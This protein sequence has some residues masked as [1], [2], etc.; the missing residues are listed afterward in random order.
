[1]TTIESPAKLTLTLRITG[2][3]DDGYHLID[4]EMTALTI[5]DLV[6]IEESDRIEV[7]VAGPHSAGVATD[8]SNLVH[9]A[10]SALGRTARVHI[11]KNIP[12]GGGL[13]GGSS[14]AAAVYRWAAMTGDDMSG[15]AARIGADVPFS[16]LGGRA[17]VT[18]IGE[19]LEPLDFVATDITLFIPPVHTP[20][21]L[22]YRTWDEMGAPTGANGNDL[23]PAAV[24]AVPELALWRDRIT[25]AI[26]HPPRLAGSG[27]TWFVPGHI[28]IPAID[29]LL[30]V[31]TTTRPDA[32]RVVGR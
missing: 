21:P 29:G 13:G 19:R 12:H 32:G 14:N 4:A 9:R 10:L 16:I 25:A 24:S 11:D 1:M 6:T 5:C 30:V 18:G 17:R 8:S 3:R 31:H 28:D 22:V 7:T 2:V 26:G 27:S 23:E 20:T 15:S